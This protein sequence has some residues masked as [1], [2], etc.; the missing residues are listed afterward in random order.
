MN[1]VILHEG[2]KG[3]TAYY[4]GKIINKAMSA[5][6]L[7][8]DNFLASAYLPSRTV[9]ELYVKL[10]LLREHPELIQNDIILADWEIQQA[11]CNQVFPKEFT[12]A[13]NN[14][15]NR[16]EHNKVEYLHFGFVDGI[17]DYHK[18]VKKKPYTVSGLIEYL[19]SQADDSLY[20]RLETL[21][22]LYKMCHGYTHGNIDEAR[23]PLLHYFEISLILGNVIPDVYRMFCEDYE[24]DSDLF[25]IDM[26]GI[27]SKN[28]ELLET[29]HSQRSTENFE[30]ELGKYS[31]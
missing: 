19:M 21:Q 1:G 5:L 7:M 22:T 17:P 25:G 24:V 9:I 28:M 3:Q 2:A 26:L 10:L 4:F 29:Q 15:I 6:V 8:E 31:K 16:R 30:M 27:I 20:K 18:I 12:D 13:F 14:R 11:C 23:F